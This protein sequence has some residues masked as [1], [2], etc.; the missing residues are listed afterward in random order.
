MA[1]NLSYN[2]LRC[3]MADD[4]HI[5]EKPITLSCGHSVCRECIPSDKMLTCGICEIK[6]TF[7]LTEANESVVINMLLSMNF[8]ELFQLI[9]DRFNDSLKLLNGRYA[10]KVF[11]KN[12]F[13][14]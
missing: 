10:L 1:S 2:C 14:L 5:L 11:L 6:N 12:F 7:D 13:K 4:E 8:S 3:A 9:S